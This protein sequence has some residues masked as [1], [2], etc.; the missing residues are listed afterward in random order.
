[1]SNDEKNPTGKP[2]IP[3]HEIIERFG[4]IRPMAAKLGVAVTTVQGWKERDHIPPGRVSQIVA[5][6]AEYDIDIGLKTE[7]LPPPAEPEPPKTESKPEAVA[8][9]PSASKQ[10]ETVKEPQSAPRAETQ[11]E[12]KKEPEPAVEP[13][14]GPGEP[15]ATAGLAGGVS[16]LSFFLVIVLLIAA[17]LTGPL[18]Q[19]RLYPGAGTGQA[20][21]TGRLDEIASGLRDIETGMKNL[22]AD[23]ENRESGLSA[24][25]D[26]LEAGGGETGAAVAE[27]MAGIEKGLET[28]KSG[29]STIESRIARLEARQD[30][31]PESV[32][33]ALQ[34]TDT[35]VADL[36]DAIAELDRKAKAMEDG[37]SS[38]NG[39]IGKMDGRISELEARPVQ[40]GE[41]I[42]AMVLAL[43]QVESAMNLGRPYRDALDRL[44]F[45]GRDDP[46]ISGSE[47]V[48]ALS[49]WADEG[50]PDRLALRRR[51]AE[52]APE[53]DRALSKG[54]EESWLDS[55][56]N[57][58]AGL[59]TVRRIDGSGL[60]PLAKAEQALEEGD[61]AMV[62]AAFEGKGSLG[63]DGDAWITLVTA[64]IEAEREIQTLYGQMIAPLAGKDVEGAA[65]Q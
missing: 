18:W 44:E 5:A 24:R 14:P 21:D 25:L 62:V 13:A 1:M 61:L 9:E 40:S 26:A 37:L 53:I 32:T 51:F 64:R 49:P 17:I 22:A 15:P 45:L 4:G 43:G 56:W 7:E 2:T 36:R 30:E 46:L 52:L 19:S 57:R 65:S 28:L 54:G 47:A 42:A 39:N 48:T 58:I 50:I 16:R 20:I 55:V 34:A 10:Q 31:V 23:I 59:V 11:P 41:K 38:V 3:D 33:A 6:A 8:A 60:T 12:I 63:S 29:L 27:Q 35:A